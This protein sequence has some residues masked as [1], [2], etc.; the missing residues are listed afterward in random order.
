MGMTPAVVV[1]L[2]RTVFGLSVGETAEVLN[3]SRATIYRWAMLDDI[4][5]VQSVTD[6]ERLREVYR[7]TRFWQELNPR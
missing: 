5:R 1:E 3:V 7:A 2:V 6:Q 4:E